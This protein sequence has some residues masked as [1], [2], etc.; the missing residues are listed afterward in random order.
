MSDEP[1]ARSAI[2]VYLFG[3]VSTWIIV[4]IQGR[5]PQPDCY[6]EIVETL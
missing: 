6:A 2:D 4:R 1:G 5:F 3:H